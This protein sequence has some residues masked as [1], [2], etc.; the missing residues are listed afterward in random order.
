MMAHRERYAAAG[1]HADGER[2][3]R[4]ELI[5]CHRFVS[6][7]VGCMNRDNFVNNAGSCAEVVSHCH[8]TSTCQPADFNCR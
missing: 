1:V 6:R 8:T 4:S 5:F 3:I 7:S 2:I